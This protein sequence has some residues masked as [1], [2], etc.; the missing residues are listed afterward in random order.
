M[1][2]NVFILNGYGYF[3]WPA[4]IFTFAS[5]IFLFVHTIKEFKKLEKDYLKEFGKPQEIKIKFVKEKKALSL[6]SF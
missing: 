4:F 6:T 1:D 3:V 2:F 5:C